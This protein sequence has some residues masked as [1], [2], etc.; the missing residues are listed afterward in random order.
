MFCF[1]LQIGLHVAIVSNCCR[2][3]TPTL[4]V[5]FGRW[6]KGKHWSC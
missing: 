2:I 1:L 5:C 6:E 3:L 4:T